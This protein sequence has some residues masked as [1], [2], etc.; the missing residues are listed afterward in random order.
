MSLEDNLEEINL[1]QQTGSVIAVKE[2]TSVKTKKLKTAKETNMDFKTRLNLR[3]ISAHCCLEWLNDVITD[4][5]KFSKELRV[6]HLIDRFKR[7]R[8]S[9]DGKSRDGIQDIFKSKSP[10][11]DAT[12]VMKRLF[13]PRNPNP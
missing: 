4:K 10:D 3:E 5:K 11:D 1:N 13:T 12:S 6:I 7:L 9:E 2:L 8:V